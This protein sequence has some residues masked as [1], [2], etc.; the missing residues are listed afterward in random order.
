MRYLSVFFVSLLSLTL[1]FSQ[2]AGALKTVHVLAEEEGEPV[3][4]YIYGQFIEHMGRCIYG[5]IWAEMLQ[6]RKFFYPVDGGPYAGNEVLWEERG[7][8]YKVPE[9]SLWRIIGPQEQVF[10]NHDAP[11]CGD[12][13]CALILE[14]N[15]GDWQGIYHPRLAVEK[16]KDYVGYVW[17]RAEGE[18]TKAQAALQWGPGANQ[19]AVTT[20]QDIRESFEQ[21]AFRFTAGDASK[22]A[23]LTFR[24]SGEGRV[25][26]AAPSLMPA[27][28]VEGFRPDTLKLMR[29]LDAPIYRWPGGNF[30]SGYDWRDGVG[31][32]DKRPP[33]K[34]PH[35]PG[36]EHNDVGIHEFMRL[37]ELI[38]TEP[39]IALNTGLGDI[40]SAAAE[41][42][43]ITAAADTE[44]G[45]KRAANGRTEAWKVIWWAVGN[46]MYGDWQLGYMPLEDYVKKQNALVD[47]I[48]AISPEAKCVAVG[49]AGLWSETML[50]ECADHMEL[51]SEHQY[52]QP[53]DDVAAHTWSAINDVERLAADHRRY[54][55]EIPGLKEKDIRIAFD[56]WN[57][58]GPHKR[59]ELGVRY[60][61]RDAFGCAGAIHAMIRNSDL[62]Y[63]ANYAQTVNVL[64]AIKTTRTGAFLESMGQVLVLYRKHFGTLPVAV[65][66]GLP[67]VDL[68]AAWTA[69][70]SA[71]TLAAV[72]PHDEPRSFQ[73]KI[74]GLTVPESLHGW[75]IQNDNPYIRN[76]A[77]APENSAIQEIFL[78][79]VDKSLT[80]DPYSV[81]LL[82]IPKVGDETVI[83][84]EKEEGRWSLERIR[85]WYA[86]E[87]FP[88]GANFVPSTASNQLEMWQA[89][90]WDP[91]TIDRELG[92][93]ADLGFNMMRVFLHDMLWKEEGAAYEQRID[94]YL[95]ISMKHG[96]KTMLTLFDSVW[97]P[98]PELGP[99]KEPVPGVHN[100][101][102][103]QSPHIDIQKN[104]EGYEEALKPY[105]IAIMSRFKDDPRV[106]AW[107]LL[108]EPA[109][110]VPQYRP[111]EG[112]SPQEKEEAH[113]I[114]VDKLFDWAREVDPSQ[115]ITVGIW[116][117]PGSRI[118]PVRPIDKLM[119]ERSDFISFHSYQNVLGVK[120][121]VAWLQQCQRPIFCTEYMARTSGSTFQTVL[122][123]LREQ[124]IAAVHWGLVSGRSQTI[125]PWHSWNEPF[126]NE[127][128]PWFHDVFRPDGTPYCEEEASVI[129][130]T[131]KN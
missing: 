65:E 3:S 115:P 13:D 111:T 69:D 49:N 126:E 6:D 78:Q 81:T 44:E 55:N 2:P 15:G 119:G 66:H 7:N 61:M 96:I 63:M 101:R 10:M 129:R 62:F 77:D 50:A 68:A 130:A 122:P 29:Q 82:R 98:F 90:T 23:R 109:N 70:H 20:L 37:C 22:H 94:E 28:H 71:L 32:R 110:P 12:Q 125:Y 51:I 100:S 131:L 92:W 58:G 8:P 11:F 75:Q 102:W 24:F 106:L 117:G 124:N 53:R 112:W 72:N 87:A 14:N 60:E 91:E 1:F 113:V 19:E 84:W 59:G 118:N 21:I 88:A 36:A 46:E 86:K 108:N 97:D 54:R 74:D 128:E 83:H 30:V 85:E 105:V 41:V 4:P 45:K 42:A 99:Q 76:E 73:L 26:I 31:P 107:D 48:R 120:K 103:L 114:L 39:F 67:G 127:A 95:D 17:L 47:A 52:W 56:E 121:A 5:G 27:D 80:L 34:N 18:V 43:Y 89:D 116:G 35:W 25:F 123:Y 38:H 57:Y 79:N 9:S 64:G 33:R 104:P 16:G 93:A 40:E